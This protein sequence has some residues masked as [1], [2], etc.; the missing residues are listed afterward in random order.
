MSIHNVRLFQAVLVTLVIAVG[1]GEPQPPAFDAARVVAHVEKQC[2]FGP[3][4]PNSAARDSAA[5]YIAHSLEADGAEVR[6][7]SFAVPDPYADRTLHLLN[8]VGSFDPGRKRRVLLMAH[9]DS[10]PWADQEPDTLLHDR[11]VP[12]AVDGACGTGILLEVGRLLGERMPEEIGVDI[13]LFDGEDYGKEGDIDYYLLGS[14]HFVANLGGY[15]PEYA[16]LLDLVGGVGTQVGREGY[17]AEHAPALTDTL[18]SRARRL[19]LDYFVQTPG[20]AMIDDHVPFLRVGIRAVDLFGYD[21]PHW[22]RLSDTPDKCDPDRIGQVGKLL[23]DFVYRY[24][25]R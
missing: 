19:G 21:Y 22:H 4:V 17:S 1:C 25:F 16:I 9:Y 7:Q 14:K 3:R 13:A 15:R 24:P 11:P 2:S 6:L 20:P 12:A 8:V 5:A 23:V 18:F 10:R